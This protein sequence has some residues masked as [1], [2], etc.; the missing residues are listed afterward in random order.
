M[1][2]RTVLVGRLTRDP[3][4]K[5]TQNGIANLRFSLAVNRSFKDARG[6]TQA[7]FPNCVAWRQTAENMAK[8]LKKGALIGVEGRIETGSYKAQDGT[9]R[10]TTDIVCD[11]VQFLE[12]KNARDISIPGAGQFGEP[13]SN[14]GFDSN[15]G[16]ENQHMAKTPYGNP[17]DQFPKAPSQGSGNFGG[18]GANGL[19]TVPNGWVPGANGPAIDDED[20]PF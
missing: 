17:Q 7:D 15:T 6:N 16:H 13:P 8:F 1:I 19:P 3:E 14:P 9:M 20:L 2:N 12:S 11:A 10:Y 5:Y 18:Y 4:L